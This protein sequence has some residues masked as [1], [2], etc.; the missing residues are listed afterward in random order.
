MRFDH[1]PCCAQWGK[2]CA[3]CAKYRN[4][5]GQLINVSFSYLIPLIPT[6]FSSQI[7]H[8]F[9]A[10]A[11]LCQRWQS[12]QLQI[13]ASPSSPSPVPP[14][15]SSSSSFSSS[16]TVLTLVCPV[17]N[18]DSDSASRSRSLERSCWSQERQLLLCCPVQP[19]PLLSVESSC[20]H[21]RHVRV[22]FP[23][24]GPS[25]MG[26]H[27]VAVDVSHK[28]KGRVAPNGQRLLSSLL[29]GV[30]QQFRNHL[31]MWQVIVVSTARHS[32]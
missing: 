5:L 19:Q 20:L 32:T 13:S 3:N 14:V 9:F 1:Q 31:T 30:T 29:A 7:M 21:K 2:S 4:L 24:G 25:S 6:W 16:W 22:T 23:T 17:C 26:R 12:S 11:P 28:F 10:A 8:K 18:C 15:C 27:L